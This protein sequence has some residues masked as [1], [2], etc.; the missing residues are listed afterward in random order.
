MMSPAGVLGISYILRSY[1]V[2]QVSMHSVLFYDRDPCAEWLLEQ[3]P[4][5]QVCVPGQPSSPTGTPLSPGA[6]GSS[7]AFDIYKDGSLVS[8]HT[9]ASSALDS[10]CVANS[11][12]GAVE[13]QTNNFI[14]GGILINWI[15]VGCTTCPG[16]PSTPTGP[17][18]PQPGNQLGYGNG[19]VHGK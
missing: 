4:T 11:V 8:Q 15:G 3:A 13:F 10:V 18:N 9:G 5:L 2:F 19:E 6:V 1:P 17:P 16:S 14:G 7:F 12:S